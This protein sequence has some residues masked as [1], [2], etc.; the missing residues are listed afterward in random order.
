MLVCRSAGEA[1]ATIG[2]CETAAGEDEEEEDEAES[3]WASTQLGAGAL[4]S[5]ATSDEALRADEDVIEGKEG[6]IGSAG[7]IASSPSS[8]AAA[9]ARSVANVGALAVAIVE[10]EFELLSAKLA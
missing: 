9:K 6:E 7:G 1:G 2:D 5:A 10:A 3:T 8:S 4:A